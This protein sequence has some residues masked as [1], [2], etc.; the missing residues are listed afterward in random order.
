[1]ADDDIDDEFIMCVRNLALRSQNIAF[2]A[3]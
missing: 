3:I 1:M 2:S